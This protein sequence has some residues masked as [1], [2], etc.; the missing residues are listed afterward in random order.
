MAPPDAAPAGQ[1]L[2]LVPDGV[3]RL[4]IRG[5]VAALDLRES[6]LRVVLSGTAASGFNNTVMATADTEAVFGFVA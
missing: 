6:R 5:R 4:V 1:A 2:L 3:G